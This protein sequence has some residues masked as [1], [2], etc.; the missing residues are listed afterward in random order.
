MNHYK[1]CS[2][3]NRMEFFFQKKLKTIHTGTLVMLYEI[4][5]LLRNAYGN[6]K[7]LIL[8]IDQPLSLGTYTS[9]NHNEKAPNLFSLILNNNKPTNQIWK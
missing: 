2:L 4:R 5:Q 8:S 6:K 7:N 9:Q 1:K 3:E